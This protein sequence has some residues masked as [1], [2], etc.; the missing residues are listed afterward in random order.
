MHKEGAVAN[1]FGRNQPVSDKPHDLV[2]RFIVALAA[3]LVLS[4]WGFSFIGSGAG[5]VL[6]VVSALIF[7]MVALS[8]VLRRI[9]RKSGGANDAGDMGSARSS[10][11]DWL[12]G[13]FETHTGTVKGSRATIEIILPIAAVALGLTAF[14]I[15][16]IVA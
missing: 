15:I 11:I 6:A 9:W 16:A 14:A 13:D 2:Y 5:L 1:G 3:W 7:F 12:S 8:G 10:A 4:A